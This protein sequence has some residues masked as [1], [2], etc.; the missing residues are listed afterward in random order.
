MKKNRQHAPDLNSRPN[1]L[2]RFHPRYF[3]FILGVI[4]IAGFGLRAADLRADPPP[5]LSWSFAP[6]TDESLNTYS[7]R[8]FSLYGRWKMDD[9]LPFVIYPLVNV[10]VTLI[11]KILG[12]GFV[13]VKLLSLIS[14]ALSILILALF[15]RTEKNPAP[16]LLSA[17]LLATCY[18][19]VMYSR[20]GLVESLEILSLLLTGFFW[21]QGLRR[22]GLMTAAGFCAAATVLLVKLSAVFLVPVMLIL[23]VSELPAFPNRKRMTTTLLY[24]SAGVIIASLCWLLLVYLPYRKEY[25]QYAV[26]HSSESPAGHPRTLS[27]YLFNTFTFGLRSRLIPRMIWTAL[28]GYLTLPWLGRSQ[29]RLLRYTLLWFIFGLLML[30]Y[31]NYRPPRYEII[32]LPCLLIAAAAALCR[33]LENGTIIP[34]TRPTVIK[35]LLYGIWLSPVVL[36]LMLYSSGFRNY[37]QPDGESGIIIFSLIIGLAL[38]FAGYGLLR[39]RKKGWTIRPG[40]LRGALVGLILI[41][42]LRLDIGQW[43]AWFTNRTY[44]LITYSK[45]VDRLLPDNAVVAGPWAPPVMIESRK[46]AIAVTDWANLDDLFKRFAVTHLILGEG[47]TDRLLWERVSPVVKEKT[48]KLLQ[49]RIRGQLISV[50]ALDDSLSGH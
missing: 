32:L 14:G 39:F 44:D 30:G 24:F 17:L 28:L 40:W 29:S 35:T 38:A 8:N 42:S 37:P 22:P 11:Y 16:A 9:F 34:Q 10:F 13:Q 18:P 48:K 50:L 31:M 26:R 45:A 43:S 15:F 3:W 25:L 19:L 21:V 5:D 33:I 27:A 23:I 49:F 41:L 1:Q 12:I 4:I 47:E 7:A 46:R 36:Q 20:L 2:F 6:Y